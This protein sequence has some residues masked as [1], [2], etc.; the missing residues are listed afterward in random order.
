[1]NASSSAVGEGVC[2]DA[3][4]SDRHTPIVIIACRYPRMAPPTIYEQEGLTGAQRSPV[5]Q[6]SVRPAVDVAGTRLVVVADL[7]QRFEI[8][9]DTDPMP[10][11]PI[12]LAVLERQK[13]RK[14]GGWLIPVVVFHQYWT[15]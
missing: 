12:E 9:G 10:I 13:L 3:G 8:D 4:V 1:M 6:R 7:R 14:I 15:G 11:V 5:R 2:A